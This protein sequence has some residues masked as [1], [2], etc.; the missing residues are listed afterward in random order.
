MKQFVVAALSVALT[1]QSILMK[2]LTSLLLLLAVVGAPA[3]SVLAKQ[4]AAA[5]RTIHR[6]PGHPIGE[7]IKPGEEQ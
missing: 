6:N 5:V 7:L 4:Q 3:I 1:T 2:T